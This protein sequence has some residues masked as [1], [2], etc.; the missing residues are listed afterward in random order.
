MLEARPQA[1]EVL[2][3][4]IALNV[5]RFDLRRVELYALRLLSHDPDS[6]IALQALT[7]AAFEQR[8]YEE[9]SVFYTPVAGKPGGRRRATR[10]DA[11][12][13][14]LSRESVDRLIGISMQQRRETRSGEKNGGR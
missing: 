2:S 1:D 8:K 11:I 13:Y 5:E 6:L 12:Q 9:A 14:R 3:N 7:M 4:L 10:E